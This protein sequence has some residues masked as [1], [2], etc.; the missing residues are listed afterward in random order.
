MSQISYINKD[1]S[2]CNK[3]FIKFTLIF[4]IHLLILICKYGIVIL[5]HIFD[6]H[7]IYTNNH[8]VSF[9]CGA[10]LYGVVFI[11]EMLFFIQEILD[12]CE[13]KYEYQNGSQDNKMFIHKLKFMEICGLEYKYI[14]SD[15]IPEN[16]K[17][18]IKYMSK[19]SL[20]TKSYENIYLVIFIST[21]INKIFAKPMGSRMWM[22]SGPGIIISLLFTIAGYIIIKF[23]I[24]LV[25]KQKSKQSHKQPIYNNHLNEYINY[26]NM[27]N[28][29]TNKSFANDSFNV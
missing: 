1:S 23:I 6:L 5:F 16:N 19:D 21:M 2:K 22:N 4:V 28:I 26:G 9:K 15:D 11:L 3:H 18:L 24:Y 17:L 27:P 25:K 29:S 13:Y 7:K 14:H 10:V 20:I 12:G 8:Y